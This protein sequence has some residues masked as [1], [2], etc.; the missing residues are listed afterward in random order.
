M[1]ENITCIGNGVDGI[2]EV[3]ATAWLAGGGG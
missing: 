2:I 1:K 3:M